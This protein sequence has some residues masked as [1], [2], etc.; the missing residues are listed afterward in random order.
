MTA[1][2]MTESARNL[3]AHS[4]ILGLLNVSVAFGI[5]FYFIG[6][7][8]IP[9]G[10]E[11]AVSL[12]LFVTI[13]TYSIIM[14]SQTSAQQGLST[15]SLFW[16]FSLWFFFLAPLTQ[17]MVGDVEY[18]PLVG[19][20][21]LYL[22]I[23]L[24]WLIVFHFCYSR[25]P[26]LK[27]LPAVLSDRGR[28][29]EI[30]WFNLIIISTALSIWIVA[31]AARYS[32]FILILR[33][34]DPSLID[35]SLAAYLLTN[36]F[37][38]PGVVVAFL[39]AVLKIKHM[40]TRTWRDWMAT[41]YVFLLFCVTNF[42]TS[43]ARF[44]VLAVAICFLMA[45][46][47]RVSRNGLFTNVF[48]LT[49][50]IGSSVFNLFRGIRQDYDILERINFSYLHE[51]HFASFSNFGH[52]VNFVQEHGIRWGQQLLGSLFFWVPRGVWQDK[53]TGTAEFIVKEY[54][55]WEQGL[56]FTNISMPAIAEFFIDFHIVGVV[57]GA[58]VFAVISANI[59][60]WSL[61]I[62]HSGSLNLR[63][64]ILT[65][66][67]TG[68]WLFINRGDFQSAVAYTVGISLAVLFVVTVA[69]R[70]RNAE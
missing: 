12:L 64:V 1:A 46:L 6:R 38:R 13:G 9:T 28:H 2:P 8:S 27:F 31:Y 61:V 22:S 56:T 35:G 54:L 14:F 63:S 16:F 19:S 48:L 39:L 26:Q 59:D 42:P 4:A 51:G 23:V 11:E 66:Y 20:R 34:P 5:I 52:V 30:A 47:P 32:Y 29:R 62:D 15:Q 57:G 49:A 37:A 68:L 67:V 10:V 40:K 17:Y 55:E 41:G 25:A 33:L 3:Q 7:Y 60:R 69:S 43:Q 24:L 50:M 21:S 44:Y 70:A 18:A 58:A 45:I 65:S 53:P 36:L